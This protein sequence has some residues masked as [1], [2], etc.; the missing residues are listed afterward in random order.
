[1][2][3]CVSLSIVALHEG[4][5]L[6]V[7]SKALSIWS[8]EHSSLKVCTIVQVQPASAV[9][10]AAAQQCVCVCMCSAEKVREGLSATATCVLIT[11]TLDNKQR[12]R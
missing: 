6:N 10:A 4:Q 11:F 12:W 5:Q 9:L 3:L 2:E 1:V 8:S 7:I